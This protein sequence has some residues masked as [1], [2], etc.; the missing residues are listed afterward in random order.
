[1][2]ME[3]TFTI[4]Q[5]AQITTLSVHTLRY[6]ERIGLLQP[7]RRTK[8]GYRCYTS[9]D[10]EWIAFLTRLRLTGMPINMMLQ[11]SLLRRTDVESLKKRRELLERHEKAIRKRLAELTESLTAITTKIGNYKQMEENQSQEH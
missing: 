5:V 2:S 7:I 6:Y 1:M 8:N 3:Q 4:N 9:A 10:I 11:Y